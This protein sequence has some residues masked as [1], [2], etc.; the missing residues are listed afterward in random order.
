MAR[1]RGSKS[2][3][4]LVEEEGESSSQTRPSPL[5]L[6]PAPDRRSCGRI[7]RNLRMWRGLWASRVTTLLPASRAP[8]GLCQAAVCDRV[9]ATYCPV[10]VS[11]PA[12]RSPYSLPSCPRTLLLSRPY[13]KA[14]R[15]RTALCVS[16]ENTSRWLSAVSAARATAESTSR[17]GG[18]FLRNVWGSRGLQA[19]KRAN[20]LHR[21]VWQSESSHSAKQRRRR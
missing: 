18:G 16:S 17:A 15:L 5:W 7:L 10:T 11:E 21:S 4:G 6:A 13:L 3:A 9:S 2:K 20:Q 19:L 8:V 1:R 14:S 12:S